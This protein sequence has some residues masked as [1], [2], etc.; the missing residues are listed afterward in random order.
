M[1][2]DPDALRVERVTDTG[3]P[4]FRVIGYLDLSTV[5]VLRTTVG[6][7]CG[8]GDEI[9]LD[10]SGLTFCDSTGVGALVWLYRRASVGTGRLVVYA[11]RKAVREVLRISGVDRVIPVLGADALPQPEARG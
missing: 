6:P 2:A 9:R 1:S 3:G 11:P 7:A 10:L 4:L 8:S 5:D